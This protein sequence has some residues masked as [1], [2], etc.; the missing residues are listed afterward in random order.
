MSLASLLTR[1]LCALLTPRAMWDMVLRVGALDS[2]PMF[3]RRDDFSC[4]SSVGTLL[5]EKTSFYI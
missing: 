5:G 3:R 2:A 4:G 1:V